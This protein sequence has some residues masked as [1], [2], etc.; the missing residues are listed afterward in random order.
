MILIYIYIYIYILYV[1]KMLYF[2][3]VH[4]PFTDLCKYHLPNSV[5]AV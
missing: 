3:L 1:F 2:G 5:I 4:S